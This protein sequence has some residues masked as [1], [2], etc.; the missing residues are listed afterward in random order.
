MDEREASAETVAATVEDATDD[1]VEGASLPQDDAD[2]DGVPAVFESRALAAFGYLSSA[3]APYLIF[4]PALSLI[5][6]PVRKSDYMR[7]HG[8]N[9]LLLHAAVSLV[10]EILNLVCLWLTFTDAGASSW[11]NM[12]TLVRW[13]LVP[14]AA[15]IF[16]VHFAYEAVKRRPA[17][18]PMLSRWAEKAAD[19][20]E[21]GTGNGER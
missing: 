13:V 21:Q 18:M 10:V 12:L 3:A 11:I 5:I 4:V 7:Y 6:P 16:G 15:T 19:G 8:W 1:Q 14:T 9:S 17:H 20:R 2:R